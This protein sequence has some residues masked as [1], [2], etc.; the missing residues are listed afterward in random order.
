MRNSLKIR[1]SR[2]PDPKAVVA[3]KEVR[4]SRR[5]VKRIFGTTTPRHRMAVL[6]PGAD[7]QQVE[8]QFAQTSA[9]SGSLE[10]AINRHPVGSKL[11]HAGGGVA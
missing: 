1:L 2:Q 9:D 3:A 11:N 8:V 6:L 10:A 7:A 5:M 4:L